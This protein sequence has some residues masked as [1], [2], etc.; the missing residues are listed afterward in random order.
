MKQKLDHLPENVTLTA[1]NK[2]SICPSPDALAALHERRTIIASQPVIN[3]DDPD[4]HGECGELVP[5][6]AVITGRASNRESGT[7]RPL[8]GIL[9][10]H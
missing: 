4:L 1:S 8:G 7:E 10:A 9:Y 3:C 6:L 5:L 2:D